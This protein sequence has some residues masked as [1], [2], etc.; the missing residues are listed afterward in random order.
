MNEQLKEVE[1]YVNEVTHSWP[2]S[3]VCLDEVRKAADKDLVIR[4][5]MKFTIDGWPTK[6]G[7]ILR[8]LHGLYSV[9]SNLSM[10]EGFLVYDKRI[11]IPNAFM[12]EILEVIHHGHQG[13]T[14]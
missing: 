3:D 14:K 11:V 13:I 9:Q 2:V 1:M 5:A 7:N 4:E 6:S 10:A 12:S 8:D